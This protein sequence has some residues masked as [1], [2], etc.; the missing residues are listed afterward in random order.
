MDILGS[1]RTLEKIDHGDDARVNS[2]FMR[3]TRS[4][5]V[6]DARVDESK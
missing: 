2:N 5:P 3:E 4:V 6:P 1:V